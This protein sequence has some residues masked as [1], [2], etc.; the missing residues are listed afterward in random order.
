[1]NYIEIIKPTFPAY[2]VRFG[3]KYG[4]IY[5]LGARYGL[6]IHKNDGN[7]FMIGVKDV[8][9][10]KSSLSNVEVAYQVNMQM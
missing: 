1:M 6:L 2:G 9:Q 4:V 8:G 3:T 5:N 10:L 7:K